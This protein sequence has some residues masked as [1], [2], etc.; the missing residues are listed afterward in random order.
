MISQGEQPKI[1]WPK[2]LGIIVRQKNT[3]QKSSKPYERRMKPSDSGNTDRNDALVINKKLTTSYL[4][5]ATTF[6]Q[7]GISPREN[8]SIKKY[9]VHDPSIP[10]CSK[11]RQISRGEVDGIVSTT[12]SL[13]VKCTRQIVT[14]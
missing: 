1:L 12:C 10:S 9:W 13:M 14:Y 8:D 7:D 2:K 4:H 3:L 5:Q 11:D 6:V